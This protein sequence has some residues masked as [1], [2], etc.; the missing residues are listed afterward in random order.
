[1]LS[2]AAHSAFPDTQPC[3]PAPNFVNVEV[4]ALETHGGGYNR[5]Y[6]QA[7]SIADIVA[8]T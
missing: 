4:A 6:L 1:M 5:Y 8:S 3:H 7:P 2:L